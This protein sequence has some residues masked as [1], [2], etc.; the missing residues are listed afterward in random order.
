MTNMNEIINTADALAGKSPWT[1][2]LTSFVGWI[3]ATAFMVK[4]MINK[5]DETADKLMASER[6]KVDMLLKLQAE[7]E[8]IHK[9]NYARYEHLVRDMI[10]V[11]HDIV[12]ALNK[13]TDEVKSR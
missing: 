3:V 8:Q 4:Y 12:T 6:E 13:L 11:Q 10:T 1:W 9:E 7:K 5:R 2:V